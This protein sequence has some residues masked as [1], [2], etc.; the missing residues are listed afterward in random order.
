M[1]LFSFVGSLLLRFEERKLLSLLFQ[2]P[3]RSPRDEPDFLCR[4]PHAF[5]A[6]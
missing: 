3:P 2:A 1:L 6:A 4:M 5:F